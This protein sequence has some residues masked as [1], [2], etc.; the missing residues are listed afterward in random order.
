MPTQK[1]LEEVAKASILAGGS[2]KPH[3]STPFSKSAHVPRASHAPHKGG[4][5]GAPTG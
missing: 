3:K 5:G 4:G 2:G 1:E